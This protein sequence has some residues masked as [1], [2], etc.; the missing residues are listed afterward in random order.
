MSASVSESEEQTAGK[1]DLPPVVEVSRAVAAPLTHVWEVLVS[2]AGAEALLGAGARLGGKGEPYHCS[3]GVSG[4]LRS[5]HPLEQLRVSW[6]E[7]PDSPASIVELDLRR[8]GESTR[9]DLRQDHLSAVSD[10]DALA[11]RWSRA[12]D[13]VAEVAE[14]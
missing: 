6:H 5:F 1:P 12:L 10:V 2:P 9:L 14:A 4:V 8:D 11:A 3:D 13:A 7:T